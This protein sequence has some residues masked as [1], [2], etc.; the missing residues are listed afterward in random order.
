M[1]MKN[2]LVLAPKRSYSG[3]VQKWIEETVLNKGEDEAVAVMT[4]LREK[5]TPSLVQSVGKRIKFHSSQMA[6]VQFTVA[7][8][9]GSVG[10]GNQ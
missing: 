7:I 1:L 8:A 2:H 6:P 9:T 5:C 3:I 10:P 4:V